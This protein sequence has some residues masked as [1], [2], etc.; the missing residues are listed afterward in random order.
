MARTT[1]KKDK[2]TGSGGRIP[3]KA[4]MAAVAL[5]AIAVA[6]ILL[7]RAQVGPGEP[8]VDVEALEQQDNIRIASIEQISRIEEM[9]GAGKLDEASRVLQQ[10]TEEDPNLYLGHLLLGYTF[11]QLGKLPLAAQ[12]TRRAYALEPQDPAVNYQLGQTEL[13]LGNTE[14][15]IDHFT[16]ALRLR[17]EQNLPPAP[18]YHITLADALSQSGQTAAA[19]QQMDQALAADR[20]GAIAAAGIVGPAAQVALARALARRQEL[21]EASELFAQAADREPH[22]ADWQFLTARAYFVQGRFGRAAPF[23]QRAV[24]LDPANPGYVK[25]KQQIDK[26]EIG[27]TKIDLLEDQ[28]TETP[29]DPL[30]QHDLFR[31]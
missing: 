1:R 24:D 14:S 8:V 25:L 5:V 12:V 3:R 16:A 17:A 7:I 20:A 11:M 27:D 2:P 23:I 29:Q 31:P 19:T 15:A 21:S 4:L 28:E 10:I 22:R 9:I 18:E 30:D 26:R 13:A 6:G